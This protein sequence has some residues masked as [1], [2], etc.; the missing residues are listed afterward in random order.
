MFLNTAT[1]GPGVTNPTFRIS[2]LIGIVL[3]GGTEL[4]LSVVVSIAHQ[5]EWKH[6]VGHRRIRFASVHPNDPVVPI[7]L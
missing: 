3:G 5:H 1:S 4:D 6:A 7:R 2:S